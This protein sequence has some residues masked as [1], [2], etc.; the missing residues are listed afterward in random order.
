VFDYLGA[1]IFE[2]FEKINIIILESLKKVELNKRE[3]G[4]RFLLFQKLKVL[5]I[6]PKK[7]GLNFDKKLQTL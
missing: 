4:P 6:V 5:Q 7:I 3:I 1:S 2:L